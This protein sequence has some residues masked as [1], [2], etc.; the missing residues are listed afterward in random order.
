VKKMIR[1]SNRGLSLT[2]TE[3]EG[4]DDTSLLD[5]KDQVYKIERAILEWHGCLVDEVLK[6]L[7]G[8]IKSEM[9]DS[10]NLVA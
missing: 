6:S 5:Y 1:D 4:T 10:V 3:K 9:Q 7:S 2:A 8:N